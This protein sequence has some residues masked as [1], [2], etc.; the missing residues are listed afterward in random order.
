MKENTKERITE[1]IDNF[2]DVLHA[3]SL[4][5]IGLLYMVLFLLFACEFPAINMFSLGAWIP[6]ILFIVACH[7]SFLNKK[8]AVFVLAIIIIFL[9]I[10]MFVLVFSPGEIET[11]E[12]WEFQDEYLLK[13][14]GD[15]IGTKLGM[16]G[17]LLVVSGQAGDISYHSYYRIHDDGSFSFETIEAKNTYIFEE[18]RTN[19]LVKEFALKEFNKLSVPDSII[20]KIFLRNMSWNEY[21]GIIRREIYIPYGSISREFNLDLS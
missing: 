19:G 10:T 15:S 20:H 7:L 16:S 21:N 18:N 14:M 2:Y 3:I 13:S 11:Q 12:S 1:F 9:C 6:L 17:N 5:L 8:T 4:I